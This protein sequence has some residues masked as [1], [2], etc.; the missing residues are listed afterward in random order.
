MLGS[1]P[2]EHLSARKLDANWGWP[3][4]SAGPQGSVQ[5]TA[6]V[7][8]GTQLWPPGPVFIVPRGQ[9]PQACW[10]LASFTRSE[11][12]GYNN[13]ERTGHV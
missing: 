7:S 9:R 13:E 11:H 1:K 6:A 3:M 10:L 2:Q 5:A 8:T 4:A 12:T